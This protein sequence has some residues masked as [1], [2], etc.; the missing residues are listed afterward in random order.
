MRSALQ[1]SMDCRFFVFVMGW[2]V[3]CGMPATRSSRVETA[4]RAPPTDV[5]VVESEEATQR[6]SRVERRLTPLVREQAEPLYF[7]IEARLRHHRVPGVS[8]AVIHEGQLDWTRGYGFRSMADL[9]P[10]NADTLFQSGSISKSV[11]AAGIMMLAEDGTIQLDEPFNG[12]AEGWQIQDGPERGSATV[13]PKMMLGHRGGLTMPGVPGWF[14]DEQTSSLVDTLRGAALDGS[15]RWRH[16]DWGQTYPP[17][18]VAYPPN[19]A[20]RYSG[21]G[22]CA[23][24]L[25][26]EEKTQAT[27]DAIVRRKLF[28]P[29]GMVRSSLVAW[30]TLA[31]PENVA[32]GHLSHGEVAPGGYQR[33][34]CVTAAGLWTTAAELATF[35]LEL[36]RA[37]RGESRLITQSLAEEMVHV[38]SPAPPLFEAY[39]LGLVLEG[40]AD[41]PRFGHHGSNGFYNGLAVMF[42]GRG[43][44]AVILTNGWD[45]F[46][47]AEE[48]LNSI[49][50]AYGWPGYSTSRR[51]RLPEATLRSYEGSYRLNLGEEQRP[52]RVA[53]DDGELHLRI[54]GDDDHILYPVHPGEAG[55][56]FILREGHARPVTF[57]DATESTNSRSFTLQM[58]PRELVG[59]FQDHSQTIRADDPQ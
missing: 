19:R 37:L 49:A 12:Q 59:R 38:R 56:F 2:L 21:G 3:A 29:L 14:F 10:V 15:S 33:L 46:P 32:A 45:G 5:V 13:T 48:I 18:H 20:W 23:L 28:E 36:Q 44:G 4:N 50:R 42:Q 7:D 30:S 54:E 31:Q 51:S 57:A 53:V 58:G 9:T 16:D 27:F 11:A 25:L 55:H 35:F 41:H 43:D 52:T 8:V 26:A 24:Q 17:V 47:L 1:A 39:G 34:P 22:Y 40:L 6:R